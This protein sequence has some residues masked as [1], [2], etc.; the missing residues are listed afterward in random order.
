M[1]GGEFGEVSAAL[2]FLFL[3]DVALFYGEGGELAG[4]TELVGMDVVDELGHG[5]ERADEVGGR[6]GDGLEAVV[7]F[8]LALL[9]LP[10]G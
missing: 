4:G 2:L 6:E 3:G 9:G 10:W 1:F 5:L 7:G 8:A